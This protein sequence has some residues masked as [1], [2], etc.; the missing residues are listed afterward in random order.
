MKKSIEK[1]NSLTG[2]SA[3]EHT[4][5]TNLKR[6]K[7][8]GMLYLHAKIGGRLFRQSLDTA[9]IEEAKMLLDARAEQIRAEQA[10][11]STGRDTPPLPRKIRAIQD[12]QRLLEWINAGN[13]TRATLTSFEAERIFTLVPH[14][15]A[16]LKQ[17]DAGLFAA[18]VKA[19]ARS[20]SDLLEKF[21]E[22]SSCQRTIGSD[23][24][25]SPGAND[26][27]PGQ[28]FNGG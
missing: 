24:C 26:Y 4:G 10:K 15:R 17:I 28:N 22:T 27:I 14:A 5:I 11:G 7:S 23:T 20:D 2:D 21:L 16:V 25:G 3:F 12:I 1:S 19:L 13:S 6:R 18:G 8:N 9:D